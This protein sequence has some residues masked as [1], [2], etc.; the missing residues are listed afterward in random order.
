[1]PAMHAAS[2]VHM[3][4]R[5]S[6][7]I[8][9]LRE[10]IDVENSRRQTCFAARPPPPWRRAPPAWTPSRHPP[11]PPG[12]ECRPGQ[13]PAPR[14]MRQCSST[15]AGPIQASD[16]H[17]HRHARLSAGC[18]DCSSCVRWPCT[19]PSGAPDQAACGRAG[20]R[21]CCAKRAALRARKPN[22]RIMAVCVTSRPS[23]PYANC[24]MD[25]RTRRHLE[26]CHGK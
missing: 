11:G 19:T 21:T 23:S 15:H 3:C 8:W 20:I 26:P 6:T 7:V 9:A 13:R 25:L 17:A 2:Q 12:G 22:W 10:F 18:A 1:M 4:C 14:I 24:T 5:H 16:L